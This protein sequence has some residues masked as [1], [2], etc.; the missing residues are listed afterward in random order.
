MAK[1]YK[2]PG[3][4]IDITAASNLVS[5]Q[6]SIVG[7]LLAVALVDITAG[8][9]GSAQIEGVFELPKLASANIVEGAGLTWDAQAR[10]LIVTG[11]D[12]GDLENCAVAV[13]VAGT[14]TATVLAKLTPGSGSLKSA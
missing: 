7:K 12:V 9:K 1:N 13:A 11:A 14:G 10:Q 5:G 3:A 2:F 4:V 8:A 6:A